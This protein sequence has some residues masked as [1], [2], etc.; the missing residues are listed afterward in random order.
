MNLTFLRKGVCVHVSLLIKE[1]PVL[2]RAGDFIRGAVLL[3][4]KSQSL[5]WSA[6]VKEQEQSRGA[7]ALLVNSS[8]RVPVT[9]KPSRTKRCWY[10]C[11]CLTCHGPTWILVLKPWQGLSAGGLMTAPLRACPGIWVWIHQQFFPG[12]FSGFLTPLL[13]LDMSMEIYYQYILFNGIEE[14]LETHTHTHT[15]T[16]LNI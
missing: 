2:Q 10:L 12:G 7:A 3:W 16:Y 8:P 11:Q 13:I 4:G 14:G 6:L 9:R 1:I 5:T 15:H